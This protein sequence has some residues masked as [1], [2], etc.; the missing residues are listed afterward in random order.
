MRIVHFGGEALSGKLVR[1]TAELVPGDCMLYNGY[2]PTEATI[3]SSI[4][5][6][7][8]REALELADNVPIP[9]GKPSANNIIHILNSRGR[10]QA[11]GVPGELCIL[12]EGLSR[13]YLNN[14]ELTNKSFAGVQGAVFQKSPLVAGGE[15]GF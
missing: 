6:I 11:I 1:D 5:S 14:P 10:L 13:G 4:F 8:A 7:S 12:G 3:N 9:I 2:G 15:N